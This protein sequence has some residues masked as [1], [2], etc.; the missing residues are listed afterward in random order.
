MR[1][2]DLALPDPPNTDRPAERFKCGRLGEP[3]ACT[4]GPSG[5]GTCPFRS[6]ESPDQACRPTRTWVGKRRLL[7]TAS[8]AI[9]VAVLIGV[10]VLSDPTWWAKP[11]ELSSAHA[12]LL[13]NLASQGESGM[14]N[15]SCSTC[16]STS[17][18]DSVGNVLTKP[19]SHGSTD[20]TNKCVDCHHATTPPAV[21]RM[22]HNLSPIDRAEIRS[23]SVSTSNGLSLVALL[24]SSVDQE[25]ISCSVCHREHQGSLADLTAMAD[26]QCQSCHAVQFDSF[27]GNHPEFAMYPSPKRSAVAFDHS[28]HYQKHF[29]E[30]T[31]TLSSGELSKLH[32]CKS[33]HG[34]D[35]TGDTVLRVDYDTCAKC[36][37]ESIQ[38][39]TASVNW[40][41]LPTV[42]EE[43]FA[44]DQR[45][46]WPDAATGW[47]DGRLSPLM[48]LMLRSDG[49]TDNQL[50]RLRGGDLSG[51]D[52]E[53][54][55]DLKLG[56]DV[57]ARMA[58]VLR[59]VASE[60]QVAIQRRLTTAGISD[61]VIGRLLSELSPQLIDSATGTWF[62][63]SSESPKRFDSAGKLVMGGWYRDDLTM[64][65][66]YR[67][68]GH[69][70]DVI[71]G[72]VELCASLPR[73]DVI[74]KQLRESVEVKSCTQCHMNASHI[75]GAWHTGTRTANEDSLAPSRGLTKFHHGPHLTSK[76]GGGCIDCHRLETTSDLQVQ[77]ASVASDRDRQ[78]SHGF[79]NIHKA[80][81]VSCHNPS[82]ASDSCV[83]CHDYHPR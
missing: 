47:F 33:C 83:T 7:A 53:N 76:Q 20:L 1:N 57:A 31:A 50:Q 42:P 81:C 37:D 2:D 75:V 16:H 52:G 24:G 44:S 64:S 13:A 12:Q 51:L 10:G 69:Q 65:L 59:D 27:A 21:A 5:K 79:A 41:A 3:G 67:G 32:D 6:T 54:I 23:G 61:D 34:I 18:L 25:S 58:A 73:D 11:G 22:A 39:A 74:A 45:A 68:R 46:A 66:S 17:S 40:F 82:A 9:L 55:D 70:D 71:R 49:V 8:V 43:V 35:A 63:S 4:H 26:S 80:D 38:V 62:S 60:G 29:P 14:Q 72:L 78:T 19:S 36:H 48:Q 77:L 28:S 15:Q 30:S 56:R